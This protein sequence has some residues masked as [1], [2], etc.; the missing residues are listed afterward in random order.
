MSEK[1]AG[2]IWA[3]RLAE[4]AS[5]ARQNRIGRRRANIPAGACLLDLEQAPF[6]SPSAYPLQ[7]ISRTSAE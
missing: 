7:G 3:T 4:T 1:A 2:K 5:C 6:L